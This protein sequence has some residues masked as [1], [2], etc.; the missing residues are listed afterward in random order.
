MSRLDDYNVKIL[1][2]LQTDSARTADE[3]AAEVGLSPSAVQKRLRQMRADG[4]IAREVAMLDPQALGGV[5]LFLVSVQ[6]VRTKQNTIEQFRTLMSG[7]QEVLQCFHVTGSF[8]FVL[9]VAAKDTRVYEGFSHRMFT[10]ENHVARFETSVVLR[11]VKFGFALPL[12]QLL[13][14][15]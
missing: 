3:I 4:I 11:S 9:L 14:A 2:L 7:T 8:D 10:E 6:L 1:T 15:G 12:D 13:A 5:A